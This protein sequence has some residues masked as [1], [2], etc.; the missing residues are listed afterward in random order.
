M[1][2]HPT[3]KPR[4]LRLKPRQRTHIDASEIYALLRKIEYGNSAIQRHRKALAEHTTTFHEWLAHSDEFAEAWHEFT[5]AGGISS[6]DF[7]LFI[8]G[9]WQPRPVEQHK[10]LRLIADNTAKRRRIGTTKKP[11]DNAA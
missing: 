3:R 9:R 10:H 1:D 7:E 4:K 2:E 11:P 8:A 6:K 5:A